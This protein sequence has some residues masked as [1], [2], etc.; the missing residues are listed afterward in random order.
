MENYVCGQKNLANQRR[1]WNESMKLERKKNSAAPGFEARSIMTL[2]WDMKRTV[3]VCCRR[4][5][6]DIFRKHWIEWVTSCA[7][8][9]ERRHFSVCYRNR[10]NRSLREWDLSHLHGIQ[11][12]ILRVLLSSL[13]TSAI[14][15]KT[16]TQ[17]ASISTR[18]TY[19]SN[20]IYSSRFECWQYSSR[21]I[22]LMTE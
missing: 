10:S 9:R 17:K 21:I 3:N 15:R 18:N 8:R 11:C 14:G 20:W 5:E 19:K 4:C 2:T 12:G 16:N 6:F 13:I 1:S 7:W 22:Y